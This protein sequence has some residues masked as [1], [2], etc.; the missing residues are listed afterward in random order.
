MCL[1]VLGREMQKYGQQSISWI[2]KCA[3]GRQWTLQLGLPL[4]MLLPVSVWHWAPLHLREE[5]LFGTWD[6]KSYVVQISRPIDYPLAFVNVKRY[7]SD[8]ISFMM[9]SCRRQ[10]C[11]RHSRAEEHIEKFWLHLAVN[12]AQLRG[13]SYWPK[14]CRLWTRLSKH[15]TRSLHSGSSLM[16]H[17]KSCLFIVR[18]DIVK[19]AAC[20]GKSE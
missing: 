19:K 18:D 13:K 7:A 3:S 17:I 5:W 10:R 4:Q 9:E 1:T 12:I 20:K 11:V 14:G 8:L 16:W 2:F 15:Y 6:Q